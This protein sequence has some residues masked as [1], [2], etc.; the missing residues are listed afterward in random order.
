MRPKKFWI[1]AVVLVL[2]GALVWIYAARNRAEATTYRYATVELGDVESTISATGK[3]GAVTTVQVGTQVSGQVSAIH[4]DFNSR[5]RKGQLIATIDPTLQQQAVREAS[6]G[7][8]RNQAE[9]AKAQRDFTRDQQLHD[10]QMISN[11][12]FSD[13][14]YALA[15]AKANA[16]S[17]QVSLERARRN[18]SYTSIYAPIDGIVVE[19]N[20]DVGQTVAA[21]LSAPQI[22]LIANDLSR[23]QILA[24][25]D[26]SDI[27]SIREGQAVRFTVQAN[28]NDTFTGTVRQLR[29]QSTTTENVVNYTVVI[30]VENTGGK[31]LPGMTATVSFLIGSAKNVLL[32][33]NAALR[34]RATPEMRAEARSSRGN[35]QGR[36]AAVAADGPRTRGDRGTRAADS[37]G[38]RTGGAAA[39]VTARTD[40][41]LWFE[42][43]DGKLANARVRAGITDGQKTEIKGEG[44]VA[45]MKVVIGTTQPARGAAAA[46]T[47]PFQQQGQQ[48]QQTRG[49]PRGGF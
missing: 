38:A 20:V 2:A 31:L 35:P 46:T 44:I 47:S 29:L 7:L 27:S 18:L 24:S 13:S 15:V 43:P 3:L 40:S 17:G 16:K 37:A 23:M 11:S 8:E 1:P 42:R 32:V 22:F 21:S 9:L 45:G 12:E 26:E 39:A 30:G 5:V 10:R 34:V 19:R 33:P 36:G 48:G 49:G 25:V 41:L 6:A 4:A 28:P 14:E